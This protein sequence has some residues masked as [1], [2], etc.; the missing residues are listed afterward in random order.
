MSNVPPRPDQQVP[1]FPDGRSAAGGAT[2]VPA[3]SGAYALPAGVAQPP[4]RGG[5]PRIDRL[6]GASLIVSGAGLV[7]LFAYGNILFRLAAGFLLGA[8][9]A[10]VGHVA[11]RRI[12]RD[13]GTGGGVA[14]A[15]IIVGW[16]SPITVTLILGLVIWVLHRHR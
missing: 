2:S 1:G 12:R 13:G 9:G 15:G 10:V 16:F 14:R 7:S 6:A 3:P 11:R 5:F 8:V 4:W